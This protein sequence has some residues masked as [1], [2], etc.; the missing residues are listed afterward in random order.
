V[1]TLQLS[2]CLELH[3]YVTAAP[4]LLA[5]PVARVALG[6]IGVGFELQDVLPDR[7]PPP[8][9]H[10]ETGRPWAHFNVDKPNYTTGRLSDKRFA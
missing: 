8:V 5:E 10:R 2:N 9:E 6:K 4:Y 3:V 7:N 1:V